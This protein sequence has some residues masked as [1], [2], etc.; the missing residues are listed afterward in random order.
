MILHPSL[1]VY[2]S[3]INKRPEHK[4]NMYNLRKVNPKICAYLPN[5]FSAYALCMR[6]GAD[7]ES[8]EVLTP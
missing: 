4:R 5:R 2:S 1:I 7:I 3:K 8:T 6:T